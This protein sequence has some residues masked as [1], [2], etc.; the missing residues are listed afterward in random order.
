MNE[1][2]TTQYVSQQQPQKSRVVLKRTGFILLIIVLIGAIGYG[3]AYALKKYNTVKSDLSS[4]QVKNQTLTAQNAQLQKDVAAK[5]STPT[6]SQ[7]F[8]SG[9][10]I[11]YP[12]TKTNAQILLWQDSSGAIVIS[13]TQVM[14]YVSSVSSDMRKTVCASDT[15]MSVDQKDIAMGFINTSNTTFTHNQYV[16]CLQSLASTTLNKDTISRAAAQKVLDQVNIDIDAFIQSA[17]I[18]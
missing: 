10:T 8:T 4:E 13:H 3:S 6:A 17:T 15:P 18:K 7:V 14:A 2:P 5:P 9:K 11:S 16:N 12:L 1:E